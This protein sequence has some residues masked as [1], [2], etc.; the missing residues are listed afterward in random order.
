MIDILIDDDAGEEDSIPSTAA[1]ES[2]VRTACAAA[3]LAGEPELC[4]RFASDDAVH[5]LNREWRGKDKTTD[6]LSFPMQEGPDFDAGESLGDIIIAAPYATKAAAGFDLPAT[7]HMLHL[8]VHGTLHL[9]GHDHIEDDEAEVMHA[10]ER[11]VMHG[12]GLHDPYPGEDENQND[13]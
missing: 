5:E 7:D 13:G 3:N 9:L 6:V 11:E 8:I 1:I 10:I 4:I 2:A 12:L